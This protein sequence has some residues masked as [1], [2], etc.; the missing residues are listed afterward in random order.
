MNAR[1]FMKL[2]N[3]NPQVETVTVVGAAMFTLV[4]AALLFPLFLI[5]IATIALLVKFNKGSQR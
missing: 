3:K 2:M 1:N 4:G 5:W